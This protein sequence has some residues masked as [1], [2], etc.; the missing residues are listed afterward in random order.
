MIVNREL[1]ERLRYGHNPPIEMPSPPLQIEELRSAS[2]DPLEAA[3]AKCGLNLIKNS[4]QLDR[5]P[6]PIRRFCPVCGHL[7][8]WNRKE[9]NQNSEISVYCSACRAQFQ[10]TRT[11]GGHFFPSLSKVMIIFFSSFF[12]LFNR[13]ALPDAMTDLD[14]F[15]LATNAV[16]GARMA[17][18]VDH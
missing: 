11:D 7:A 6:Q 18:Y 9:N 10:V 3:A 14:L 5:R 13:V 4:S 17:P 1:N 8:N 2:V 15:R 12:Y 16:C